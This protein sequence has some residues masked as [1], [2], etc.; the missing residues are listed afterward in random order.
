MT[1]KRILAVINQFLLR[2]TSKKKLGNN[3]NAKDKPQLHLPTHITK[4]AYPLLKMY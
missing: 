3:T 1:N 2:K 4:K